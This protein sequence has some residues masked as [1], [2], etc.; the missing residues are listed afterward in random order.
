MT[1][2]TKRTTTV[3]R[4]A[5]LVL[6]LASLSLA[7]CGTDSAGN[8][9]TTTQATQTQTTESSAPSVETSTTE[10]SAPET[11][12]PETS[13]EPSEAESSAEATSSEASGGK[14][15]ST[16]GFNQLKLAYVTVDVSAG[17]ANTK[18]KGI[19]GY[20]VKVCVTKLPPG[21]EKGLPTSSKPWS[22]KAG[23]KEFTPVE[24]G[25]TPDLKPK[26]LKVGEC[27]E[28]YV[29]FDTIDAPKQVDAYILGYQPDFGDKGTWS[30][31]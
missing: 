15:E 19:A 13:S 12:A 6:G 4:G 7:A 3:L 1:T 31:D 30:F 25:Y 17:P 22:L 29:S 14:T 8:D 16:Q 21:F 24:E 27:N 18:K 5:G 28:G 10:S 26:T 2:T 11:S 9:A 23:D 20:Y